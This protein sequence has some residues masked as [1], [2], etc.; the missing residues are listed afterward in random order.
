MSESKN[1]KKYVNPA[2]QVKPTG[3]SQK[4]L[5]LLQG[6]VV[7]AKFGNMVAVLMQSQHH[8]EMRLSQLQDRVV[9]PLLSNQF[10][11]AEAQKQG[12]GEVIP[13]A[14]ILWARVADEVHDRLANALDDPIELSR[15]EWTNGDNYWIVDAI[16]QQRFLIPL[17]TD[18][19]SGEFKEHTVYY[20]AKGDQGVELRTIEPS[21]SEEREMEEAGQD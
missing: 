4:Q 14:L 9:P 3:I 20:K 2:S 15:E 6:R 21:G 12:G 10:R 16:G 5:D 1:K 13:V 19:R 7:S 18:L 17:L 11:I 8:K